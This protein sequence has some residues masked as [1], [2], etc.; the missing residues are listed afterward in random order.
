MMSEKVDFEKLTR[1]TLTVLQNVSSQTL[2]E[3]SGFSV[4]QL[5]V[6]SVAVHLPLMFVV[7]MAYVQ[8]VVSIVS[9]SIAKR[10]GAGLVAGLPTSN[11]K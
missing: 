11:E 6:N 9:D 10:D 7:D 8:D 5:D 2:V 3:E 4:E 1:E